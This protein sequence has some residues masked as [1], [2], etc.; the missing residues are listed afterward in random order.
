MTTNLESRVEACT[1]AFRRSQF[2]CGYS[3][4]SYG[5]YTRSTTLSTST[6]STF[7]VVALLSKAGD[8]CRKIVAQMSNVLSTFGRLPKP[9][10]STLSNSTESTVSNS[11]L[12]PVCTGPYSTP[13]DPLAVREVFL[14]LPEE[15]HPDLDLLRIAVAFA[16]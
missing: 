3:W 12:S 9:K 6:L 10:P 2:G 13:W 4:A 8:I 16:A 5:R 14:S 7:D 11:T 15:P 1:K